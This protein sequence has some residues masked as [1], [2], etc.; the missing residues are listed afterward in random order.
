M[1]SYSPV[2]YVY[3]EVINEQ[4]EKRAD[5]KIFYFDND[6]KVESTEGRLCALED[7]AGKGMY[8][9]LDTGVQIRID[10]IITL[11]GKPGAAFDEY[12]SFANQCLA[13]TGGYDIDKLD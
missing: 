5:G 6:D 8:I 13:C 11:F 4:I 9:T 12:D 10:R 2:Q 7:V 1:Q 3:R